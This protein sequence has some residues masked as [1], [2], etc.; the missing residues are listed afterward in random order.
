MHSTFTQEVIDLK[1]IFSFGVVNRTTSGPDS[2]MR[3]NRLYWDSVTD[4]IA[5]VNFKSIAIPM[6]PN[7]FNVGRGGAPVCTLAINTLFGSAKG[8]KEFLVGRGIDN[9]EVMT[10]S[11]QE[12]LASTFESG[13]PFE[14]FWDE[15]YKHAVDVGEMLKELGG[16]V[17]LVSPTP[18]IGELKRM[19]FVKN[20]FGKIVD[21]SI[22]TVSKIAKK[23]AEI[24]IKTCI[25][26]DFY[27]LAHGDHIEAYMEKCAGEVGFAPDTAQLYIA[28][29]DYIALTKKYAKRIGCVWFSDTKYNDSTGNYEKVAPE[30]PQSG[31]HQRV[32]YNLGQGN[33]DF[34]GMYKVLKEA[35]YDGMVVLEPKYALDVAR[36]ILG[37]RT[38][39]T[40]FAKR[41]EI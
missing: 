34:D 6:V 17:L 19:G 29:A 5:A 22:A 40:D 4:W 23:T 35:G 25:K 14:A 32:Y 26:N 11:A 38:F 31:D 3:H 8:Y 24:G 15:F 21:D 16:S 27:T 2:A 39:W 12:M 20:D 18:A 36:S 13:I 37:T 30:Y 7:L 9:V 33:V 28:K 1:T 10:I 41:N